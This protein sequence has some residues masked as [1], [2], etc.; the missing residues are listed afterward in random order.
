[1][2]TIAAY[3]FL[4]S[5]QKHNWGDSWLASDKYDDGQSGFQR[6]ANSLILLPIFMPWRYKHHILAPVHSLLIPANAI[7]IAG[8]SFLAGDADDDT[9][10]GFDD[11]AKILRSVG[12]AIFLAVT[13]FFNACVI[14]TFMTS[15]RESRKIHPTL[16][17]MAIVGLLL[18]VRGV[19]G[20]LQS[21]V[22]GV[23]ICFLL[24]F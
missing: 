12:S 21:A 18:I 11:R 10:T 23:S 3:L 6:V 17:I 22:W 1:M 9:A 24:N 13:L 20:L 14:K 7:I 16:P 5:W 19:F 4:K 2:Q 15:R 8:G